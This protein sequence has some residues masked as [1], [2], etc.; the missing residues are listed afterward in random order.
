MHHHHRSQ[1]PK[2]ESLTPHQRRYLL[3]HHRSPPCT[4]EAGYRIDGCAHFHC[5]QHLAQAWRD[6]H[7]L[8]LRIGFFLSAVSSSFSGSTASNYAWRDEFVHR[9]T[10]V[11]VHNIQRLLHAH[12]P[13]N[14]HS[15]QALLLT[16]SRGE[17]S[18]LS[19][20]CMRLSA[21]SACLTLNSSAAFI[22]SS[23][24]SR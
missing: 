16:V 2:T 9:C 19:R 7:G 23:L 22:S 6:T 12:R 13:I 14:L 20:A 21:R 1:S 15:N 17:T 18:A 3:R 10:C 8:P 11:G 5:G 24:C 4:P